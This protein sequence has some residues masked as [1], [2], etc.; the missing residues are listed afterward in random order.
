MISCD[1]PWL[2]AAL[3]TITSVLGTWS[4]KVNEAK[5]EWIHISSTTTT[6]KKSKQ[7]GT[8]LGEEEDMNHRINKASKA[9][10]QLY[11]VWLRR[12]NI[13]ESRRL[14]LYNALIV[15]ILLYNCEVWGLTAASLS[16]IIDVF[17][18][19]QLRLRAII[20]SRHPDHISNENL[21]ARCQ[22]EPMS[23]TIQ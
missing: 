23:E 17:H 10:G 14:R 18:R 11:S 13:S 22:A 8:L 1:I 6:W 7:L 4:L 12:S 2:Q 3:P 5:T 9:F 15:P 21:Y 19:R 16:T 20:G